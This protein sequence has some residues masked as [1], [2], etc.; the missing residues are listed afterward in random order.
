MKKN[1]VAL[2]AALDCDI[3]EL[4]KAAEVF[5]LPY[6]KEGAGSMSKIPALVGVAL[7]TYQKWLTLS[8][9]LLLAH[10][11]AREAAG[12]TRGGWQTKGEHVHTSHKPKPLKEKK[13]KKLAKKKKVRR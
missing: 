11:D 8:P 6:I 12:E 2:C 3:P 7:S 9:A 4:K 10:N 13:A 1:S 5:V